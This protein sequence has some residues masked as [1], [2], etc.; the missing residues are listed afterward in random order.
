MDS[1]SA[2]QTR[3]QRQEQS[4]RA[5]LK[6]RIVFL[7][8]A[9]G[10]MIQLRKLEESDFRGKR[11][12]DW[13]KDLKG[14]N[15]LLNLTLPEVIRDIHLAY[16]EAGADIIET[17]TFNAQ[18]VS[19]ADYDMVSLAAEL[20]EAG[21]RVAREAADAFMERHPGTIV[22]VAGAIG[23]TTK[24]AS[25]ATDNNNPA[26]RDITY[27]ELVEAYYEQAKGLIEAVSYTHLTLPTKRIV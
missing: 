27:A 21:G 6:E 15:D 19:L 18:A 2:I 5:K 26:A 23:P 12:A 25:V 24:T 14:N 8:G 11:F 7:D 17:N 10:T 1:L 13:S 22:W 3:I 16:L 4:L 9:M 20:A